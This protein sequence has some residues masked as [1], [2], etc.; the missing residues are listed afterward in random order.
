MFSNRLASVYQSICCTLFR[1][2][3]KSTA[4]P[5][6]EYLLNN[7]PE[8]MWGVVGESYTNWVY[9]QGFFAALIKCLAPDR[10]SLKL[11]DLG[12]GHGKLAP[13]SVFFTHPDGEY[14]GID[15]QQSCIDFCR[16]KYS[17]L[18]RVKFHLSSDFNARYSD[19][20]PNTPTGNQ[21]YGVD[22]P[23]ASEST[24]MLIAISLFTHLQE[25]D[26]FGYIDR[27]HSIL[28][29]DGVAII[30]C[31]I[32]EEP[33][34]QPGFIFNY[35]PMLASLLKFSTPLPPSHN[36]FTCNPKLPESGIAINMMG[37]ASLIQGKFSLE[38][39]THG[40]ATGGNDP[41]A[42]HVVVLRR[43][44]AQKR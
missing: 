30:T 29:P 34:K 24:D 22:W 4:W 37:L 9:Q 10:P 40:S 5:E 27:I 26:A 7:A 1:R 12:C 44:P 36:W 18:P 21:S 19:P 8:E 33:R 2:M 39:L 28:K 35:N 25:A 14:L 31:H 15:I 17:N 13:V 23:V 38:F 43:L 20:S 11:V 3:E 16:R 41:L 32:V 6:A 42:Q